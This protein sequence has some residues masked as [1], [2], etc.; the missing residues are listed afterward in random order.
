[1]EY[2][3]SNVEIIRYFVI[4]MRTDQG[5]CLEPEELVTLKRYLYRGLRFNE[6]RIDNVYRSSE[7]V[8]SIVNI[9]SQRNPSG[10]NLDSPLRYVG[11]VETYL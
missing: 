4:E 11:N 6:C 9:L 3:T 7:I 10:S 2:G 1:M 8:Y 5:L